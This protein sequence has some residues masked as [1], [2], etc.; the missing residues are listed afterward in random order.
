MSYYLFDGMRV[1]FVS[2]ACEQFSREPA[3]VRRVRAPE[4]IRVILQRG[5]LASTDALET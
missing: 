5:A 4:E 3:R 1:N 2:A